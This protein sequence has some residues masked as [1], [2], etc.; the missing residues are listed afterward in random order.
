[1]RPG[2]L[3]LNLLLAFE[4]LYLEQSVTA[5]GRRLGL[6]QPA[7]SGALARLRT[8]L[9]DP[10]LERVGGRMLP[11]PRA[12]EIA[13][14]VLST[15]D[16]L[17][18]TLREHAA[19]APEADSRTFTLASTD[20]TSLAVLPGIVE[21]LRSSA[22][23]VELHV[24]G[25]DKDALAEMLERNAVDAAL[26]VFPDPSERMV[27]TPLYDETFVGLARRGHPAVKNGRM[28][29]AD[30]TNLPHALVTVRRDARGAIDDA[31][32]KRG[33]ARR[34]AVTLPHMM[35]L[36]DLLAR[37]DLIAA[38]PARLALRAGPEVESF[39]L[40]LTV[41]HWRVSLLWNPVRRK[42]R[43]AA[44]LRRLVVD[45]AVAA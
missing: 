13:S 25:Y 16:A 10:V 32:A 15:L 29:L 14:D 5:A 3:D 1:M 31:L 33:L 28:T 26:G 40:P 9:G 20:Y 39:R 19:F 37:S 6:G 4:A 36:P 30:F 7:M 11:T 41:P 43:A 35:S 22:P 45:A 21:R 34:I 8:L 12:R 2:A 17:R 42:D 38:A 23:G 18:R 24:V 44:W 27:A